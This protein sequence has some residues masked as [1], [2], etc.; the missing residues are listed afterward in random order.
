MRKSINTLTPAQVYRYAVQAF[1][2][3]L[4]LRDTKKISSSMI[5]GVLFTAAACIS[6]LSVPAGG[7]ATSPTSTPSPRP[8][9][10]ASPPSRRSGA[11]SSSP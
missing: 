8:S 4:K 11:R 1:Q 5:L 3:H 7:S 10:P 6:S 2:P 9:T